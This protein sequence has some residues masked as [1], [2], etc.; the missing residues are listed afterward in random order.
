LFVDLYRVDYKRVLVPVGQMSLFAP[1][2]AYKAMWKHWETGK[3]IESD[4][5]PLHYLMP[6]CKPVAARFVREFY[7]SLQTLEGPKPY[8]YRIRVRGQTALAQEANGRWLKKQESKSD[9]PGCVFDQI[10]V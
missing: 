3:L 6:L 5:M 1:N 9:V 8:G 10:G 4:T 2:V 7:K